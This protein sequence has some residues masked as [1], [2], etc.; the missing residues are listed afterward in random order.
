MVCPIHEGISRKAVIS[1]YCPCFIKDFIEEFSCLLFSDRFSVLSVRSI[2]HIRNQID[3]SVGIIDKSSVI[4][5]I[6]ALHG[7]CPGNEQGSRHSHNPQYAE[8]LPSALGLWYHP[9][10]HN[11][12]EYQNCHHHLS[13]CQTEQQGK[14]QRSGN[15]LL[16]SLPQK[17]QC[18]HCPQGKQGKGQRLT[19]YRIGHKNT[20][21]RK[22]LRHNMGK[23]L[24]TC[25]KSFHWHRQLKPVSYGSCKQI[26]RYR[27]ENILDN[28]H[29]I[30]EAFSKEISE[31]L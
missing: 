21:C 4:Y 5:Q 19:H 10:E 18:I 24:N 9:A 6:I 23:Y 17:L 8:Q 11:Q 3:I 14:N 12:H 22:I 15:M 7:I 13:A 31:Q 16:F 20:H 27:H 26:N 2:N 30:Q 28:S 1:L 25:N 29:R